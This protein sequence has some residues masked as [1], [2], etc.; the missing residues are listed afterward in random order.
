MLLSQEIAH[1]IEIAKQNFFEHANKPDKWFAYKL[2]K[3]QAEK[4]IFQLK[5]QDGSVC[6]NPDFFKKKIITDYYA[7][8]FADSPKDSFSIH[9][10]LQEINFP[11]LDELTNALLTPMEL[12]EAITKQKSVKTPGSDGI[13]AVLP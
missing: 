1:K 9:D 5:A 12:N 11:K 10:Y 3:M 8:L 7:K 13:P 2:C 6:R 4:K